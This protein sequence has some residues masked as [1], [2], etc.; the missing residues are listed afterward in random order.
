MALTDQEIEVL[1]RFLELYGE[2]WIE[3]AFMAGM[4]VKDAEET[5]KKLQDR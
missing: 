1:G 5:L 3:Y 2:A 4:T